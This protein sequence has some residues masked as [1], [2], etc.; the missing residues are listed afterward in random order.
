MDSISGELEEMK[1]LIQE[2]LILLKDIMSDKTN[3]VKDMYLYFS[4]SNT[5]LKRIN[6]ILNQNNNLKKLFSQI[7]EEN[8]DLQNKIT[9]YSNALQILNKTKGFFH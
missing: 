9:F 8:K 2:Y 1:S 4:K 3:K 7:Q 6:E 5:M